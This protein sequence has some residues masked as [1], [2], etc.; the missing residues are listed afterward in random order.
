MARQQFEVEGGLVVNG[1]EIV[2]Y[3]GVIVTPEAT[4]LAGL[5]DVDMSSLVTDGVLAYNASSGKW[6][7][8]K[9]FNNHNIDAGHY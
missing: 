7:V 1:V 4:S 2:N 6:E 5:T 8:T 9:D 3:E